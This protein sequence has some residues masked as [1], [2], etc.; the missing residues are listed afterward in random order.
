MQPRLSQVLPSKSGQTPHGVVLLNGTAASEAFNPYISRPVTDTAEPEPLFESPAWFPPNPW[1]INRLGDL[2]QLALVPAQFKGNQASGVLRRFTDLKLQV[3]YTDTAVTDF[4]PPVVWEVDGKAFMGQADFWV[5]AQD[6][7]GIQQVLMLYTQD[8]IHW[9]S[10]DLQYAPGQ[11]RWE[12]HLS[13]L[14]GQ[15]LFYIQVVDGA[16][17]VTVTSNKGLFFEPEQHRIYLPIVMR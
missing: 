16:G 2:P 10:V 17:N 15:F 4:A 5:T 12:K 14:T 13:G 3:Y 6:T 9:T 1:A 8:G 7:S 11:S